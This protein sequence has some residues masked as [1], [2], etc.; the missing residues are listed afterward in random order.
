MKRILLI[1]DEEVILKALTRLLERNHYSVTA[2]TTVETAKELHPS[3]FDLILADLR[4]PGEPGTT[5]IPAADPVP[6]IIMTSHASVRSAVDAM[7]SGAIDYIAKP[8]DHDELMMIIGRSLMHTQLHAQNRALKLDLDRLIPIDHYL[9]H[10]LTNNIIQSVSEA[11]VEC[12]L[13]LYGEQGTNRE[14]IARAVHARGH[15]A[16]APF[17]VLDSNLIDK[18]S[19]MDTLSEYLQVA[20]NGTLLV[21]HPENLSAAA[22]SRLA[23]SLLRVT[24][25]APPTSRT[26][27]LDIVLT[28]L[29]TSPLDTLHGDKLINDDLKE[30]LSI[31]QCITPLRQRREDI[32]ALAQQTILREWV[33]VNKA[34]PTFSDD[35]Q[36]V[37]EAHDWPGNVAELEH[38]ITYAISQ[39]NSDCIDVTALGLDGSSDEIGSLGL[40]AYF[41]YAVIRHQ[42]RLSE[43]ELAAMLGISRKALWERRQKMHLLR[44]IGDS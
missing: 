3:S 4:L 25:K 44:T 32:L 28:T 35:A 30:L 17:V 1:E 23:E 2:A 10:E 14:L 27:Q 33:D 22:Q 19:E 18:N 39:T 42:G 26:N 9:D 12:H 7:R 41:R 5:I 21:R 15:R 38:R 31:E 24:D 29:S 8:F 13:H 6:V 40:D 20:R 43:T 37:L 36:A 16:D 11:N 34:A